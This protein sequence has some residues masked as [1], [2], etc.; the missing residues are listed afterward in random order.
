[1]SNRILVANAH[2]TNASRRLCDVDSPLVG[3]ANETQAASTFAHIPVALS[4]LVHGGLQLIW[5]S[6]R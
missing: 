5:S 4:V 6:A 3:G 1:M 2:G